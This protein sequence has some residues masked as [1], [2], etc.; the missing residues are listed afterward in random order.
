MFFSFSSE[1]NQEN[2]YGKTERIISNLSDYTAPPSV[3]SESE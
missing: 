2:Y 1:N 3:P